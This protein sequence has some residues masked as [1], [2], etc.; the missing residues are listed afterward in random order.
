[1]SCRQPRRRIPKLRVPARR[2]V[3]SF[4]WVLIVGGAI[5]LPAC[6]APAGD[7]SPRSATE[8]TAGPADSLVL[9]TPG[10]AQVWFTLARSA[11]GVGG[12]ACVERGL[13]IRGRGRKVPVPLLYTG[14]PPVLLND[15]TM[16]A[17]LWTHC[18]PGDVYLVNLRN[19]QPVR[20]DRKQAP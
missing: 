15:S 8:S 2:T 20:D 4:G 5:P 12:Q 3:G 10:G 9:T 11:T 14:V 19:G 1:M 7:R 6:T 18:Q 16:R 17:V 13:E